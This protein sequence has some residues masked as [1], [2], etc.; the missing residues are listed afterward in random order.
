MQKILLVDDSKMMRRIIRGTAEALG[1]D[2]IEAADG[3]S[4]LGEVEANSDD[5]S[6]V[7]LDVN[8]PGMDGIEVLQALKADERFCDIP[9]VM[10]TTRC[11]HQSIL[12]AIKAG[13]ANYICKPFTG[14]EL[15]TKMAE[16]LGRGLET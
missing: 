14:A 2:C 6:L 1:Y 9:V 12:E 7:V 8:L 11:E 13:A 10:V 3:E 15:T 16:S 4:A 5:L